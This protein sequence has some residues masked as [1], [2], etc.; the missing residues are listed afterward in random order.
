[1]KLSELGKAHHADPGDH[2]G[3]TGRQRRPHAAHR[4]R[5]RVTRLGSM[6]Q[7]F[8]VT[9]DQEETVIDAGTIRQDRDINL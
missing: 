6:V 9:G 5:H 4:A 2:R 7:L 3:R 1:M 8:L